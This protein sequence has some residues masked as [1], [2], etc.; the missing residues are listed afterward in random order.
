MTLD[1]RIIFV[2]AMQG[3]QPPPGRPS[4]ASA[5]ETIHEGTEQ[6]PN[7][8]QEGDPARS[9]L[10]EP[11]EDGQT[12]S[13]EAPLP[14]PLSV[15]AQKSLA[16]MK[17][18]LVSGEFAK[19]VAGRRKLAGQFSIAAIGNHH[20]HILKAEAHLAKLLAPGA[21]VVAESADN[22][23]QLKP[24]NVGKFAEGVSAWAKDGGFVPVTDQVSPPGHMVFRLAEPAFSSG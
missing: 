24:E 23:V 9:H 7:A 22:L 10:A 13:N 11:A 3:L 15:V 18:Q 16:R 20:A 21:V 2:D 17:I 12:A 4:D 6:S 19:M 5:L 1:G 14:E 8:C